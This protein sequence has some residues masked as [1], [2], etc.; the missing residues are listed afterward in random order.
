MTLTQIFLWYCK[1]NGIMGDVIRLYYSI[2]WPKKTKYNIKPP[3]NPSFEYWVANEGISIV[4]I[5]KELEWYSHKPP[6]LSDKYEKAKKKWRY[7]VKNNLKLADGVMEVGDSVRYGRFGIGGTITKINL[8]SSRPIEID[9]MITL[10]LF[11][12]ILTVNDEQKEIKFIIKRNGKTY[13]AD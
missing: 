6:K 10:P 7:F 8:G 3:D 9:S 11:S 4:N 1:L 12:K 5:F 13:G 2:V